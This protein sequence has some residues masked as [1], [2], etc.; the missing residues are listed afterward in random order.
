MNYRK[1]YGERTCS[2]SN[3]VLTKDE[4]GVS[5]REEELGRR[6]Q[7]EQGYVVLLRALRKRKRDRK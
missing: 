5:D 6:R 1:Q 2:G 4:V 3:E 7:S